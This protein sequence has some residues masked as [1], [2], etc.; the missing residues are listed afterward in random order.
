MTAG[1][2]AT[3]LEPVLLV[4]AL[5]LL[6]MVRR[7][8]SMIRGAPVRPAALFGFAAFYVF[9]FA[10]IVGLSAAITPWYLLVLDAAIVVVTAVLATGY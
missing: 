9:L 6:I 7:A 3:S 1:P 4:I 8:L 2:S 10:F 5:A